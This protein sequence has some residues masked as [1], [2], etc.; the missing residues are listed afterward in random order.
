[1]AD[2]F[3][4]LDGAAFEETVRPALAESRR[5]RSF[6]PCRALCAALLPAAREYAVKYHVRHVEPLPAA[7]AAGL[8][9]DRSTWRALVSEVL[10]YSAVEIPELQTCPQTLCCLLSPGEFGRGGS[11]H[12]ELPAVLQAHRGSRAL[13]FGSA[14]YRPEHAGYNNAGDVARLAGY[15]ASIRPERWTAA[16]LALL[17]DLPPEE[18][19]EELAFAREWFPE[20]A[21]LFGR[22]R[23]AGCVIVHE[24]MGD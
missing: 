22:A 13:T 6:E 20:L 3:L 5:Q 15:L 23:G 19:D 16:D 10:L 1:M 4:L 9:F 21:E 18:R 12:E 14:V 2:Y 7:V 8:P 17:R 11:R 24:G